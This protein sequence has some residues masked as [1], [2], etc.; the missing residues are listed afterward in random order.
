[1]LPSDLRSLHLILL[2]KYTKYLYSTTRRIVIRNFL[3]NSNTTWDTKFLP[4]STTIDFKL[5]LGTQPHMLCYLDI[6]EDISADFC[7]NLPR[8]SKTVLKHSKRYRIS[9]PLNSMS[10]TFSKGKVVPSLKGYLLIIGLTSLISREFFAFSKFPEM[11][12]MFF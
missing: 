2:Y 1:M 4:K 5:F 9:H 6:C 11:V 7:S 8:K 10:R 12:V 3:L